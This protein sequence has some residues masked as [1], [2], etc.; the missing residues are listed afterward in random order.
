MRSPPENVAKK[1]KKIKI[2]KRTKSVQIVENVWL[3]T[4]ATGL[5]D[6]PKFDHKFQLTSKRSSIEPPRKTIIRTS[7][8]SNS[9]SSDKFR[10]R[11]QCVRSNML[12]VR[13]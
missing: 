9:Q 6:Y 4:I 2:N 5:L 8:R 1:E 13:T 7:A 11:L 12:F 10:T 3:S